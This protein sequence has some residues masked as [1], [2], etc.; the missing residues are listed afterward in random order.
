MLRLLWNQSVDINTLIQKALPGSGSS[1]GFG[2]E[3]FLLYARNI[4]VHAGT[5]SGQV[6]VIESAVSRWVLAH[7]T[8]LFSILFNCRPVG[9]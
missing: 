9:K 7:L 3:L 4:F 1:N 5:N 2:F 6:S 8:A